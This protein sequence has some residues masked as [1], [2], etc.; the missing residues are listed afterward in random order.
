[1]ADNQSPTH[2]VSIYMLNG[3]IQDPYEEAVRE[4]IKGKIK[5]GKEIKRRKALNV[6]GQP[7]VYVSFLPEQSLSPHWWADYLGV[8][9]VPPP[10]TS[11]A[12]AFLKG[13]HRWFALAFG[14]A[15]YWLENGCCAKGF[16]SLVA[17]N[18]IDPEKLK[19]CDVMRIDTAFQVKTQA[20]ANSDVNLFGFDRENELWRSLSGL[21]K[22]DYAPILKRLSGNRN[23]V[24]CPPPVKA[25]EITELLRILE[26]CYSKTLDGKGFPLPDTQPI[27]CPEIKSK[28]N[29]QLEKSLEDPPCDAILTVPRIIDEG[30]YLFAC[31]DGDPSIKHRDVTIDLYNEYAQKHNEY[32]KADGSGGV[33]ELLL[34]T[35]FDGDPEHHPLEECFV[36]ETEMDERKYFFNE[37]EWYEIDRN[38]E[39][40]VDNYLN[41]H[42]PPEEIVDLPDCRETEPVYN[43][44]IGEKF[45]YL[46]L[47]GADIKGKIEPCD[48]FTTT[49]ASANDSTPIPT[50][51]HVKKSTKARECS[52]LF[53][54]GLNSAMAILGDGDARSKMND[55]IEEKS[56]VRLVKGKRFISQM[57]CNLKNRKTFA[58]A[59]RCKRNLKF[60]RKF[61]S[62]RMFAKKF[63]KIDR[64]TE[65]RV[66]YV[67][68]IPRNKDKEL[69]ALPFVSRVNLYK[70]IRSFQRLNIDVRLQFIYME[71]RKNSFS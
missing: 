48:L 31:L 55:I 60:K 20:P 65:L 17:Q 10:R 37:G 29:G 38:L 33:K 61:K 52:H 34:F 27:K 14:Y 19:S 12:L 9:E 6:P 3:R 46:C 25:N 23:S 70:A 69:S 32:F 40:K 18:S 15:R 45:D 8:G 5:A 58:R 43:M 21:V 51:I 24:R 41:K 35:E 62:M 54:Q 30:A 63:E 57:K 49:P 44:R 59:W 50:L 2:D 13:N 16:G 39:R 67:I 56:I 36:F 4:E 47:D 26:V 1:M 64:H 11:S 66:V 28:L 7:E 22:K 53:N 68:A 42:C 71:E